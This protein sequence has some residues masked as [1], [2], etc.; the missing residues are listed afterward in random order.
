[1]KTKNVKL[2]TLLLWIIQTSLVV[3][4]CT[5]CGGGGAPAV[6]PPLIGTQPVNLSVYVGRTANFS[7]VASGTAPLSY[8]WK[9]DGIDIPGATTANYVLTNAQLLDNGSIW[10]VVVSNKAGSVTSAAATLKVSTP[11]PGISLF[12]GRLPGLDGQG[13]AASFSD[14]SGITV[15]LAG[16]IYVADFANH[17]IRKI[18]PSGFVTTLAGT[19]AN[20]GFADGQGSAASFSY[21]EGICVDV[22]GNLYVI[23]SGLNT[24]RK[25]TPSGFVTTIRRREGV[26]EAADGSVSDARFHYSTGIAVDASGNLYLGDETTI[27]K[28]SPSGYVSILAGTPDVTGSADGQGAA[29]RFKEPRGIALDSNGN[30]YVADTGNRSIRKISPTGY[31]TTLAGNADI[32]G[33]SDG[34]GASASFSHPIGIA[35]DVSGN[36]FVSDRG[37]IRKINN[38]GV[39]STFAG[40]S[41]VFGSKDGLGAA[42]SF[43]HLGPV[44]LDASG[45]LY[46]SDSN[47]TIRK[48]STSGFVTTLAGTVKIDDDVDGEG[49]GSAVFGLRAFGD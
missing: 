43:S 34:I 2:K 41:D 12:A 13:A 23:D 24:I 5:A 33:A 30:I 18:T 49:G 28:I 16:N 44:A 46:V 15:D 36:V 38:S 7:V 3:F 25:I 29:A 47:N 22:N 27:R 14:P 19:A 4:F 40:T 21:P 48:I 20:S 1:M 11:I 8:Q 26:G 35:V 10:T 45:N 37:A 32:I 31:V 39:V 6:T 17:T 9:R 42:A